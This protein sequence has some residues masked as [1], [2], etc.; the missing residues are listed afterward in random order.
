[1]IQYC[2]YAGECYR[3]M[4]YSFNTDYKADYVENG[5]V[6]QKIYKNVTEVNVFGEVRNHG[7][8]NGIAY[9]V[10]DFDIPYFFIVD[11]KYIDIEDGY[12]SPENDD[13]DGTKHLDYE[14]APQMIT[15]GEIEFYAD[16]LPF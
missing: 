3:E 5:V 9:S 6:K 1:M 11:S 12:Y 2:Q 4:R 14:E 15:I 16:D 7:Y 13:C 8:K 10:Y